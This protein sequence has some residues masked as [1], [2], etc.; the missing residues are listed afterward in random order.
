MHYKVLETGQT[1]DIPQPTDFKG[2]Q[3]NWELGE[4][5]ARLREG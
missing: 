4:L 5:A 1:H 3:V 2:M